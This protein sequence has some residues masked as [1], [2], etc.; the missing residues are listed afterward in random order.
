M[1]ILEEFYKKFNI[2]SE[3]VGCTTPR[4]K[5]ECIGDCIDCT[6]YN[7]DECYPDIDSTM[8]LKLMCIY[9]RHCIFFKA[10]LPRFYDNTFNCLLKMMI[11]EDNISDWLPYYREVRSVL[12]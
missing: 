8:L 6:N 10:Y 1:D 5:D 12:M 9:N 2:E 11:N 7:K 3:I 4:L